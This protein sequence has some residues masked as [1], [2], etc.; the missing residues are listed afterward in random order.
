MARDRHKHQPITFRPSAAD[1]EWLERQAA[2]TGRP[3]RR[4]LADAVAAYRAAPAPLA[5]L[6]KLRAGRRP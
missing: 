4:I 1:R 2:E 5:G 6:A 3:V